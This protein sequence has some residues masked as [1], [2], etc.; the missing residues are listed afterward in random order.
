MR[1]FRQKMEE[2]RNWPEIGRIMED[3]KKILEK[4]VEPY[5]FLIDDGEKRSTTVY[6]GHE[7][8]TGDDI[9]TLY[10]YLMPG[11]TAD[12]I[13]DIIRRYMSGDQS[14]LT[15]IM[16]FERKLATVRAYAHMH[17]DNC[18]EPSQEDLIIINSLYEGHS[19]GDYDQPLHIIGRGREKLDLLIIEQTGPLEPT[20]PSQVW[21]L[22]ER[23]ILSEGI[24]RHL[25]GYS[26]DSE[27]V[28]DLSRFIIETEGL[29]N[30]KFFPELKE[31]TGK[32]PCQEVLDVFREQFRANITVFPEYMNAVVRTMQSAR[33]YNVGLLSYDGDGIS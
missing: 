20:F 15:P 14:V 7:I 18:L 16:E 31:K 11:Y 5:F 22:I 33:N 6:S 8:E 30:E 10:E 21:M 1:T 19:K 24:P 2:V 28:D 23:Y 17:P 25:K 3:S 29:P 12:E 27:I 4:G 26:V 9:G 13:D 32:Y